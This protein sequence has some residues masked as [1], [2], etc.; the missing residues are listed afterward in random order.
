MKTASVALTACVLAIVVGA[1]LSFE[2]FEASSATVTI[3]STESLVT[4]TTM[5]SGTIRTATATTQTSA[6][7]DVLDHTYDIP[8]PNPTS[9]CGIYDEADAKVDPGTL[10]ISFGVTGNDVVD[11]WVLN[12][13][14]WTTWQSIA[15]C[16]AVESYPGLASIVNVNRWNTTLGVPAT[17]LY[18]FVF[19]N[20]NTE[21]V[22]ISL[23]VKET[24]FAQTTEEL[25]LTSYATQSSTWL[26]SALIANQQLAGLGPTFI[27]GVAF[28]IVGIVGLTFGRMRRV[29]SGT[30]REGSQVTIEVPRPETKQVIIPVPSR[31]GRS[32]GANEMPNIFCPYCGTQLPADCTS[33]TTCGNKIEPE[34]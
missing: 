11:F 5:T 19:V 24:Y 14:Q 26:T 18:D 3:T 33:C 30:E 6:Q 27:L 4:A 32:Q 1:G 7:S 17:D 2:G 23:S 8:S 9:E 13:Q 22:S 28:L 12:S 20:K 25:F 21:G 31:K 34:E 15:S 29:T 10:S 16:Q